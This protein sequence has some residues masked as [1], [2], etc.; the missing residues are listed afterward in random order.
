MQWAT[1]FHGAVQSSNII[2]VLC[3]FSAQ[4]RTILTNFFPMRP[5]STP[6]KQPKTLQWKMFSCFQKVGKGALVTNGLRQWNKL[7]FIKSNAFKI[8][9]PRKWLVFTKNEQNSALE[10]WSES[11]EQLSDYFKKRQFKIKMCAFPLYPACPDCCTDGL[12]T[13]NLA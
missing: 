12:S 9:I 5:F 1:N 6:W 3:T 8:N 7:K 10:S 11:K 2:S 13:S 4:F